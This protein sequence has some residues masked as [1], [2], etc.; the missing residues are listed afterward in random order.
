[1]SYYLVGDRITE[2]PGGYGPID[3]EDLRCYLRTKAE[4]ELAQAIRREHIEFIAHPE[5][6][7]PWFKD[8][9]ATDF[10]LRYPLTALKAI[11]AYMCGDR[12]SFDVYEQVHDEFVIDIKEL[13]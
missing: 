10:M 13:Q 11:A 12:Y 6:Q 9:P 5:T 7:R 8:R 1:M 3:L 4:R 2:T